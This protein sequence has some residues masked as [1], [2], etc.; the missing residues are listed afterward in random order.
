MF[1]TLRTLL[2]ADDPWQAFNEANPSQKQM[3]A[4]YVLAKQEQ[5]E[6]ELLVARIE[7]ELLMDI[8]EEVYLFVM[9]IGYPDEVPEPKADPA[10]S[11]FLIF[12]TPAEVGEQS[13]GGPGL[14]R[15]LAEA[16]LIGQQSAT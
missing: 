13:S 9:P 2:D 4:L 6:L 7:G 3:R 1:D 12:P 14:A 11:P 10:S 15:A 8:D 5:H 16:G